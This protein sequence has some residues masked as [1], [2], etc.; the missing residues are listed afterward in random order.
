MDIERTPLPGIGLRQTLTTER[1]RRV[2]VITHHGGGVRDLVYD[3]PDDP[4]R[5]CSLR[6]TRKEA[7][8]L[9]NLLGVLDLLNGEHDRAEPTAAEVTAPRR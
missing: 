2:G 9:A 7:L 6:L 3:D 4:D 1:G 8:T 5:T